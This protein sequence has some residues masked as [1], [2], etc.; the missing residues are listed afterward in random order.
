L[1]L[2]HYAKFHID[3]SALRKRWGSSYLTR[4]NK[5]LKM[6][7]YF[8]SFVISICVQNFTLIYQLL[9]TSVGHPSGSLWQRISSNTLSKTQNNILAKFQLPGTN[10]KIWCILFDPT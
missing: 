5:I 1:N 8:L 2:N 7:V 10:L 3:S 9:K 6:F 4:L